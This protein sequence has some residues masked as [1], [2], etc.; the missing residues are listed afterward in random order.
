MQQTLGAADLHELCDCLNSSH[1]CKW[2]QQQL[3]VHSG[4][5][6]AM[7]LQSG[8]LTCWQLLQQQSARLRHSHGKHAVMV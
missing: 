2:L 4:L 8:T 6:M 5:L 7:P 1:P 3:R